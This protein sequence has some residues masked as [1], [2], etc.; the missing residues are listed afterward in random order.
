MRW[1]SLIVAG[2]TLACRRDEPASKDTTTGPPQSATSQ[3]PPATR[4]GCPEGM[5][6]VEGDPTRSVR[7]F[8]MDHFETTVDNYTACVDAKA[9]MAAKAHSQSTWA[10]TT[11]APSS[12][13]HP[14]T[15]VSFA[16]AEKYC[17]WR[18]K[19]VPTY[20][21]WHWAAH[22]GSRQTKYPW[23]NDEFGTDVC[24]SGVSVKRTGTCPVGTHR[25]DTSP[26]GVRDLFGN[27][28]E[29][30]SGRPSMAADAGLD[31]CPV[32]CCTAGAEGTD[33]KDTAGRTFS[34]FGRMAD[35]PCTFRFEA[36]L[37]I[38]CVATPVQV[39]GAP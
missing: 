20:E 15:C 37:G 13:N 5:A 7:S 38:R 25:Q 23:G 3:R 27:A 33:T 39:G 12:G 10:C 29:W 24:L 34:A 30:V 36:Q 2:L 22:G 32:E 19:H 8:C 16:D 17:A 21:E 28:Q 18:G 1:P 26:A 35:K 14:V 11:G 6:L 9:C 4:L 31:A